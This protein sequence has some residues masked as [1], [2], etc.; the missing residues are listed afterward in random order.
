MP[1]PMPV[2]M[3]WWAFQAAAAEGLSTNQQPTIAPLAQQLAQHRK[4]RAEDPLH[5]L[6]VS[7]VVVSLRRCTPSVQSTEPTYSIKVAFPF[8][9]TG[10]EKRSQLVWNTTGHALGCCPSGCKLFL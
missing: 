7:V 10:E 2:P 6:P 4:D 9:I 8:S 1:E 3:S 5:F